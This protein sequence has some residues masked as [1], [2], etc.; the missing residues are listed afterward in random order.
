MVSETIINFLT[1]IVG[2]VPPEFEGLIYVFGVFIVLYII[3]QFF[4]LLSTLF[5]VTK[6]QT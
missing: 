4:T 2:E 1:E 6:W 5:G 3:D